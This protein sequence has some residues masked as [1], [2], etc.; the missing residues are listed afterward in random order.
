[1]DLS[2][3]L[4]NEINVK[5]FVSPLSQIYETALLWKFTGLARLSL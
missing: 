3:D 1:M 4:P 2:M 5:V